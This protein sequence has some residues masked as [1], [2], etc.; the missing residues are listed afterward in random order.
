MCVHPDRD[1]MSYTELKCTTGR[2]LPLRAHRNSRATL[3]RLY[4]TGMRTGDPAWRKPRV[5]AGTLSW[6]E[7]L[8][9]AK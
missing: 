2:D 8:V 1:D 7:I 6:P 4:A 9:V 3:D 5:D